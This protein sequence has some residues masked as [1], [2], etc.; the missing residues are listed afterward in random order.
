[1]PS[2]TEDAASKASV[3][4]TGKMADLRLDTEDQLN[5]QVGIQLHYLLHPRVSYT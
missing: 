2:D 3:L 4:A 5:N 1:M